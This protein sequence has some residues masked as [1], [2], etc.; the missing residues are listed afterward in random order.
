MN[1]HMLI[2][3][4]AKSF[5]SM[6]MMEPMQNHHKTTKSCVEDVLTNS[7]LVPSPNSR[8]VT[9]GSSLACINVLGAEK[10][11][12]SWRRSAATNK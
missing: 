11:S 5:C 4:E 1:Q 7:H 3:V 12:F 2:K 9:F 6:C 8:T 10:C